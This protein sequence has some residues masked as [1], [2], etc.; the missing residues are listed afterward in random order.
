[1]SDIYIFT[2]RDVRIKGQPKYVGLIPRLFDIIDATGKTL[3]ELFNRDILKEYSQMEIFRLLLNEKSRNS[4]L[5]NSKYIHPDDFYKIIYMNFQQL[6]RE[7]FTTN[8]FIRVC[9]YLLGGHPRM[10]YGIYFGAR[11]AKNDIEFLESIKKTEITN[12]NQKIIYY[13]KLEKMLDYIFLFNV[14]IRYFSSFT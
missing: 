10:E 6:E 9:E 7:N 1:M 11:K 14:Q 5:W 13:T 12:K 3:N 4:L 8:E 2:I